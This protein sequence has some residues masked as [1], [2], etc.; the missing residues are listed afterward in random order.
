MPFF[1]KCLHY[2]VYFLDFPS[3]FLL[4]PLIQ[5]FRDLCSKKLRSPHCTLSPPETEV[6]SRASV[7]LCWLTH[8]LGVL[9]WPL[10]VWP[11]MNQVGGVDE[12]GGGGVDRESRGSV[13]ERKWAGEKGM[14]TW[15]KGKKDKKRKDKKRKE[16]LNV[17]WSSSSFCSVRLNFHMTRWRVGRCRRKPF[18]KTFL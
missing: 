6:K 10:P 14:V 16:K 7:A 4:S 9:P 12:G 8:L 5:S 18:A 11:E 17:S 15:E 13:K 1:L 2:F 3:H